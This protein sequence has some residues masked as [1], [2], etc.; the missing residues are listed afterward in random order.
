MLG[1]DSRII[2][3]VGKRIDDYDIVL[4]PISWKKGLKLLENGKIGFLYPPYYRPELRP[5]MA[6]TDPLMEE[7]LVLFCR[8]DL[9]EKGLNQFPDDFKGLSIGKKLGYAPGSDFKKASESGDI[10][11][12]EIKETKAI[13]NRLIKGG[14]DCY[15]N[16]KLSTIVELKQMQ[17]LGAYDGKS[18]KETVTLS[19]EK[20]YVSVTKNSE[21]YPYKDDFVEKI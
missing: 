7:K 12:V 5:Y 21:K 20:A 4:K 9:V 1:I 15:V 10:K 6:Y 2:E 8:A 17:D 14:L 11:V 16:D 19:I 13:L 3:E 18:I